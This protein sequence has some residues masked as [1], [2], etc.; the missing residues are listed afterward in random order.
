[1]KKNRFT[2]INHC[3]VKNEEYYIK[4]AILSVLPYV[5]K[6]I[7]FDTG[8][9]DAT[10]EIIKNIISKPYYRK[11]VIF[12]EC[13]EVDKQGHTDLR[14]EMVSLTKTDWFMFLAEKNQARLHYFRTL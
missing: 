9:T 3:L 13:G 8:S 5:D 14:N 4:Y 7:I 10:V 12:K 6:M 1:M 2:I 11:K